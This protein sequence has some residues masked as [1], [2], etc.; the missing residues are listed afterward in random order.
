MLPWV[1]CKW[2]LFYRQIITDQ[3]SY[4]TIFISQ[5]KTSM[6]PNLGKIHIRLIDTGQLSD[7]RTIKHGFVWK[8][9]SSCS[10]VAGILTFFMVPKISENI[11]RIATFFS[12]TTANISAVLTFSSLKIDYK[13]SS[14][15]FLRP[16]WRWGRC[17]TLLK[18][19][20]MKI[21]RT[22]LD[23]PT[24]FALVFALFPH[25]SS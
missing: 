4:A 19:V 11:K 15:K 9:L 17:A 18:N 23:W 22:L 13:L 7:R 5:G 3:A 25:I 12:F 21:L 1:S 8:N 16:I 10:S 2:F 14:T 6:Y 24:L 20:T